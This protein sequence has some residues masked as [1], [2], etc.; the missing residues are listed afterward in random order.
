MVNGVLVV[1][2]FGVVGLALQECSG[3]PEN[4]AYEGCYDADP[5]QYVDIVCP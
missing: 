2:A 3:D 4:P 5:T 1:L